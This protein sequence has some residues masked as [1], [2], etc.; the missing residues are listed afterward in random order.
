MASKVLIIDDDLFIR[1]LLSAILGKC[2]FELHF[3]DGGDLGLTLAKEILP[4]VI[5]LDMMM[6]VVDGSQVCET[7]KQDVATQDIP[8]IFVTAKSELEDQIQGLKLGAQDYICKPI[9]PRELIARVEAA[10]RVK[11]LQ[12]QLKDKLRLQNELALAHRH[13]IEQHMSA[14]LGQLAESLVH[15]LNNPLAAVIGFAELIKRR[16]IINDE[17]VLN[18]IEMIR[19]M[20]TRASAKLSSL[21]C[22]AKNENFKSVLNLNQVVSDVIELINA[23]LLTVQVTLESFLANPLPDIRGN[24]SLLSRATLALINNAVDAASNGKTSEQRHI[25]VRTELLP[26]QQIFFS[27]TDVGNP[28]TNEIAKNFFEPFFTTKGPHHTGL[29]LYLVKM[30]VEDHNGSV[31]WFGTDQGNTFGFVLPCNSPL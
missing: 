9:R 8:V 12:D 16:N 28:I 20:G 10:L 1:N 22:I 29:G 19:S 3:A 6:P 15:E 26:S 7:L 24:A 30:V 14:M 11:H 25:V 27:V 18:H 4:D 23:R 17:Q 31:R 5:L 13:L 21:L 2:G